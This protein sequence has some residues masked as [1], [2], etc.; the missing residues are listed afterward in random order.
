M[1]T[2]VS[3]RFSSQDRTRRPNTLIQALP[4]HQLSTVRLK[5]T[6]CLIWRYVPINNSWISAPLC[7]AVPYP[8]PPQM[9]ILLYVYLSTRHLG[10]CWKNIKNPRP[11]KNFVGSTWNSKLGMTW[12]IFFS[13]FFERKQKGFF[14]WIISWARLIESPCYFDSSRSFRFEKAL[15]IIRY[16]NSFV[17]FDIYTPFLK[18]IFFSFGL[19]KKKENHVRKKNRPML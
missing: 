1:I 9:V 16:E 18:S 5:A 13:M 14:L 8:L 2:L 10:V 15:V 3:V 12:I 7:Y 11:E 6:S 17:I 4:A 19:C